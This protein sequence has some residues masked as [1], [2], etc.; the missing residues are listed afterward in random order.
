M[1]KSLKVTSL[2]LLIFRLIKIT[3]S[4]FILTFSAKYFGIK[5][6]MDIW[7]IV[8]AFISTVNLS[9]WGPINETFRAKFVFIRE[10]EG[11]NVALKKTGSLL[12][13]VIIVSLIIA[14]IIILFSN[15]IVTLLASS[16]HGNQIE[17]FVSI[18]LLMIPSFIINQL[19]SIGTSIL[20]AYDV[21]YM[22]EIMGIISSLLNLILI[23]LLAPKIGIQTLIIAQ[24]LSS[25][26]LIFFIF[27][28]FKKKNIKF[29]RIKF[30][31]IW[32]D[33]KPFVLF[34][35]PF[36][37]PYLFAQFN[38][39]IEKNLSNS[40]GIGVVSIVNYASQFKGIIQA[41]F[42][43]VLVS[44]MVPSLAKMYANKNPES[45]KKI[46]NDNIQ[47]VF[48]CISLIVPF[49]FAAASPLANVLYNHG[50]IDN[51][52]IESIIDLI[53]YYSFSIVSIM[54]YL[55]FG[56][57]LLSQQLGKTYAIQGVIA[58]VIT[59]LINVLCYK[60]IG[61]N[62]F[63]ISLL[64]SHFIV[65]LFM[66]KAIELEGKKNIAFVIGKYI[67]LTLI[68]SISLFF[69]V[70]FITFYIDN[71]ILQLTLVGIILL[72]LFIVFSYILGFNM[73]QYYD[74][75]KFKLSILFNK[76]NNKKSI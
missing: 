37:F 27:Y 52:S 38:I 74:F 10:N 68:L 76:I 20:N 58:Q 4:I 54:L 66:Y 6:E 15:N 35:L 12:F 40:L 28:Y 8:T 11:K 26:F 5:V 48:V 16:L 9:L 49:L 67:I 73:N 18:L 31:A 7:L 64:I 29:P 42:T 21:F 36:F 30:H 46:L 1:S 62:I 2:Y 47:I 59:I 50:G 55:I 33:I 75:L 69:V 51:S 56:L 3:L 45:F 57:T 61:A 65:S 22:P 63:P 70:N 43:S 72:F 41:V 34:S 53:R 14:L 60:I 71:L 23:L 39:L 44:V 17:L 25:L 13:F 32:K 19:T 24:Y